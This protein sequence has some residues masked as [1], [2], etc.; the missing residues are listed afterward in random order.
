[1][2]ALS[3]EFPPS[4]RVA[5]VFV[6]RSG[7]EGLGHIGWG[8][9]GRGG[10]FY[11]GSVENVERKPFAGPEEMGFW[12][13]RTLDPFATMQ[14]RD[15]PYDEYKLF[16]VPQPH[17]K[18]AWK[19]VIEERQEPYSFVHYNCCDVACEILHAYGCEE[20]P[21][22]AAE[23]VPND[24]YDAL[25]GQSLLIEECPF[26]SQ[27]THSQHHPVR[28]VALVIPRHLKGLSPSWYAQLWRPWEELLLV[29]EMILGHV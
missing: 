13:M 24:W 9:E 1:M 6:R 12:C 28:E 19:M 17:L 27:H 10:W 21:D 29:W 23:Y 22:P 15:Y 11:V 3:E 5:L 14:H 2:L 18:E 20:L 25:P 16:F 7:A 8:F 4:T 26:L